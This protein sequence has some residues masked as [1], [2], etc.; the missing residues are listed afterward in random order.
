MLELLVILLAGAINRVR[1]W[2]PVTEFKVA[3]ARRR[4]GWHWPDVADYDVPDWRRWLAPFCNKFVCAGYMAV[5]F[6]AYHF[7]MFNNMVDA[8]VIG[9]IVGAGYALWAAP[10]WGDY[11]DF[12]GQK[13]DE[14]GFID[15]L[16]REIESALWLDVFSMVLRGLLG[17]PLFVALAFY[18]GSYLPVWVGL[19]MAGQALVYYL[20]RYRLGKVISMNAAHDGTLIDAPMVAEWAMGLLIGAL[21]VVS[22]G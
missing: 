15:S 4:G 19:G 6:G 21:I 3:E 11:W 7:V 5:L 20:L 17:Y 1:G 13:N 9:L 12:T 18:F 2:N 22:L 10:G 16:L 14:V 8:G